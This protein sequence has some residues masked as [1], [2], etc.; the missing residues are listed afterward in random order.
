MNERLLQFIWQ[1]QH[2]NKNMLQTTDDQPIQVI[3]PG[4]PNNN[5]GPDFLNAKVKI[6]DTTWAG[7]IELHINS[8]DWQLHKHS[9][10]DNY[11][12][13]I[14]HVVWNNDCEPG[15]AFPAL[16]LRTI[17]SKLLLH[18]YEEMMRSVKFIPCEN[19]IGRV[20]DIV[21]MAWKERMMIERL[22]QKAQYIESL[23]VANNRHWEETCWWLL[24]RNFG[25]KVN[26]DSFEMMARQLPLK[27][28]ARHKGR[29]LKLE[30]L[31]MGQAGLLKRRVVDEYPVMLQQEYNFLKKKY[32]FPENP[33]AVHLLRMRPANFPGIRLSQ[34]AAV[35]EQ[36]LH[37]FTMILDANEPAEIEK[38][39]QVKAS[40]YW[41]THYVFDE[42]VNAAEKMLGKEM[43]KNIFINTI[44]PL[45]YTYGHSGNG[46]TYKKKALM[47]MEKTGP[48]TNR[49]TKGFVN[50]GIS[51]VTAFDSQALIQ[52]KD[53]YCD[54]KLCLQCAVGNKILHNT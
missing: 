44:V 48:E 25:A 9:S 29:L 40:A 28:L 31:L 3:F 16:E 13:V 42:K 43:M 38:L 26:S 12:N 21:V 22:E 52:L 49:I 10:D 34:L 35:L 32:G 14:L 20:N 46:E 36:T 2:F 27:I 4:L 24:A 41:D 47:W 6:G 51:N 45:L 1:Y 53:K 15:L 37:L 54:Q 23:L 19:S 5:Q 18:K 7:S 17:V 30:A 8:S 11:R 39:F 33:V 50:M